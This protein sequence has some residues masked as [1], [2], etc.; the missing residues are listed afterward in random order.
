MDKQ[1]NGMLIQ[2]ATYE[3]DALGDR[4][5]ES[6]TVG[7]VTTTT[8][9][10]FDA[11][12]NVWADLNG[13]S[14]NALE[15]RRLFL[16]GADEV[17]ARIASGNAAWY[18]T[19]HEGSV[20]DLVNN[21]GAVLDH[22]AYDAFGNI[23]SETAPTQ[24][25]RYGFQ[26]G[27]LDPVTVLLKFDR[28][29][30]DTEDDKWQE[31]DPTGLW[32][33]SDPN[34]VMGNDPTN[35]TDPMGLWNLWNPI[36][37]G[38]NNAPDEGWGDV[39]NPVGNSTHW[40]ELAGA[41]AGGAN[42]GAAI[43]I[44]QATLGQVAAAEARRAAQDLG[45]TTSGI[46]RGCG[47]TAAVCVTAA[48]APAAGVSAGTALAT[49]G[50]GAGI[51]TVV[52][53]AQIG[54]GTRDHIDVGGIGTAAQLGAAAPI[55][56][57]II[58]PTATKELIAAGVG[59]AAAKGAKDLLENRPA[60]GLVE[61]GTAGVG[62]SAAGRPT[63]TSPGRGPVHLDIGGE[64]RYPVAINVNPGM[65]GRPA[66]QL[67]TTMTGGPIP[68]LV[69]A[70]GEQ[71]PFANGAADL[72]TIE[73]TPITQRTAS[74]VARVIRPGGEIRLVG[75]ADVART[76]HQRV[77]NAV[78]QGATVTQTTVGTGDAAITTTNIRVPGGL[79]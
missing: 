39:L 70:R 25:D 34:R 29:E 71:L 18:L 72:I 67:P 49:A 79:P 12:G 20:V 4:I 37:W 58:G 63:T 60:E 16:N 5:Q 54:D 53:V 17:F 77:I 8:N 57:K 32:P 31:M 42:E 75:P 19:D 6:A 27:Q 64:G 66:G 45:P 56:A 43:M 40:S 47:A 14:G 26:G 30:D 78:P 69:V 76:L 10:A 22:R 61:L 74:E 13:N 41:G 21:A 36:T 68:N 24:G 52:Q 51:G 33:D 28:R 48:A 46:V 44:N 2:Q 3:Y 59:F 9:Y 11:A 65:P 35:L 7:G 62:Y 73:N 38:S 1:S 23:T 55:G 50:A 15:T